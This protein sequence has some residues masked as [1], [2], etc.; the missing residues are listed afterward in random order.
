[1]KIEIRTA[2]LD[3]PEHVEAVLK[4]LDEYAS[5]LSGG[6]EPLPTYTRNNLI[7]ELKVR[8]HWYALLA[9]EAEVAVA[10]A[11][12][13]E[14]FSTFSAKPILN[15]HDFAVT[16]TRQKRGIGRK[17]LEHIERM[18]LDRGCCKLTL[19]VLE[20]NLNAQKLYRS[21]GFAGYE[22]DPAMGRAMYYQKLL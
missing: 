5:G 4:L 14:G 16:A 22:L 3:N 6:G 20:G 9:F 21:F 10:L 7:R 1:M 11:I 15:I 18:A 19:E 17:L 13:Y 2:D 12:G 8:P